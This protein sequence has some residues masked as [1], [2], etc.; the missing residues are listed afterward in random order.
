[1]L[2]LLSP[3][4]TL[5]ME[6]PSRVSR[7]TQ[8]QFMDES[9][10]LVTT[11]KKY[12]P[13]RLGTLMNLSEKLATLNVERYENWRPPFDES[14]ARPAI[15][16]FR[17]DVYT[18]FDVDTMSKK[19][20]DHAQKHVRILSGLYGVLRPYDLM[21]AYR[22][23]MGT[24]LK[25]RRGGD[26]Y[27]FWG[28]RLTDHLNE[29]LENVKDPLV[30]NLASNEY[31]KSIKPKVLAAPLVS[32]VFH[33]QK[34]GEYKMISFFA[35]K[36]RGAMAR[37]LVESRAKTVDDIN[38]FKGLGYKYSKKYSTDGKP[39]FTRSEKAAQPYLAQ[40]G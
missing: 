3:A 9:D 11:L 6:A 20:L 4:K 14:N 1:M 12:R 36:A 24:R 39:V 16:A 37:Y 28:T 18:G 7:P 34:N 2:I 25:T 26:L 40:P 33:D 30:V 31:F 32:P 19:D 5:D 15:Q 10:K 27:S 38:G 29:E 17:G 35:K 13:K 8:P 22:L 23:E 21:Q